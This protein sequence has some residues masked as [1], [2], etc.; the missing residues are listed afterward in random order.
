[1]VLAHPATPLDRRARR[2]VTV[3]P[4]EHLHLF[5]TVAVVMVAVNMR[6]PQADTKDLFAS[7]TPAL[8]ALTHQQ[9]QEIYKMDIQLPVEV[10]NQVLGYLGTR[11][12]QEV[13]HLIQA[14]QEAAKPKEE[15]KDE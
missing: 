13:F 1:V 11:P 15:P 10:A 12:Y 9:T 2:V 3:V 14:V 6:M 7:F 8:L 5:I 4:Q